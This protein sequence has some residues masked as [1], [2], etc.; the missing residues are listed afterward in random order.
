MRIGERAKRV[1]VPPVCALILCFG[2]GSAFSEIAVLA[3]CCICGFFR[4]FGSLQG[5]KSPKEALIYSIENSPT[6]VG[7]ISAT[8]MWY[9]RN[10][11]SKYIGQRL[12]SVKLISVALTG[13]FL[14]FFA[15]SATNFEE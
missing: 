14:M 9:L 7:A 12:I 2:T 13:D 11:M 4:Y 6:Y 3:V 8:L 15:R 5:K 10:E 1:F